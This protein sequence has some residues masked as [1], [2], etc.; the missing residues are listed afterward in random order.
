[1]LALPWLLISTS[2]GSW[3]SLE[4]PAVVAGKILIQ[5]GDREQGEAFLRTRET[6]KLEKDLLG[7]LNPSGFAQAERI[8][9]VQR[10]E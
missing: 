9:T 4:C 2:S 3:R 10:G 1:M 6:F 7:S 8:G 5:A